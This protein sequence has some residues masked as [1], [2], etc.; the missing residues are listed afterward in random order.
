MNVS[1]KEYV[2]ARGVVQEYESNMFI[3]TDEAGSLPFKD[4]HDFHKWMDDEGWYEAADM[5]YDNSQ[6]P[7]SCSRLSIKELYLLY[8]I[9]KIQEH[10]ND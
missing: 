8:K 9:E 7:N 6:D 1:H 2:K 5:E 3:Y 4:Y 10:K